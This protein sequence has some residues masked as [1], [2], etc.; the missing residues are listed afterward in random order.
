MLRNNLWVLLVVMLFPLFSS[1]QFV[2]EEK[3][4]PSEFSLQGLQTFDTVID[5]INIFLALLFVTS[6]LGF[7]YSGI[8]FV[9]AGGAE[10]TLETARKT[11]TASVIGFV[12]SLT[13]YIIINVI[14]H[15]MT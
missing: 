6:I 10:S 1:A 12:L 11:M 8:K 5:T 14:K 2:S 7:I 13:G 9:I 15:F 4:T 3:E